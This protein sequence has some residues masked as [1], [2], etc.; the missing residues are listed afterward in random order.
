MS[1]VAAFFSS[2]L[3]LVTRVKKQVSGTHVH[4]QEQTRQTKQEEIEMDDIQRE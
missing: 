4:Y 3:T 1:A 2:F